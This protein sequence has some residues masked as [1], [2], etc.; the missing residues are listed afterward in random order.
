MTLSTFSNEKCNLSKILFLCLMLLSTGCM[1]M[2]QEPEPFLST[3]VFP[4]S[5]ARL[6]DPPPQL[7]PEEKISPWGQE[8][9]VGKA[10]AE[11]GD[12]YRATTSFHRA[13]HLLNAVKESSSSRKGQM[14]HALVLSYSLGGKYQEMIDVW[15]READ[16]VSFADEDLGRD[17]ISLLFEA[18]ERLGRQGEAAYLLQC[19]PPGD[20][21]KKNLPL[22]HAIASSG[23]TLQQAASLSPEIVR[24][25][26]ENLV[27]FYKNEKKDPF[28]AGL[29]NAVLPGAGYLYVRQYQTAATA[30]FFNALF[31]ATSVELF[32]AK[33]PA[34]AILACGFEVGWY[35]GG[36]YGARLAAELYNHRLREEIGKSFLEERKLF[37]LQ[38]IHYKW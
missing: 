3:T 17:T 32:A 24:T 7:T 11:E 23:E 4:A 14:V 37:P 6:P 1:K 8:Y 28:T 19:L 16:H 5:V 2:P 33:L 10:F 26:V 31:I 35:A 20:V 12:Y 29:Y 18:Y 13:R 9:A 21:L 38:T 30:F 22:F 15:E 27:T 25:D 36:I 34:A